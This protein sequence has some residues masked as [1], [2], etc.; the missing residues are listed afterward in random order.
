MER[1]HEKRDYDA[2][3]IIQQFLTTSS[4]AEGVAPREESLIARLCLEAIEVFQSIIID[5]GSLPTTGGGEETVKGRS[6]RGARISLERSYSRL[7]LWF[8]GYG[9]GV[10]KVDDTFA[11]SQKLRRATLKILISV[12]ETLYTSTL[13]DPLMIV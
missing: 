4:L 5:L 10:G 7:N 13:T 2:A 6:D 8:D 12:S 9:I 11:K 1:L 3:S